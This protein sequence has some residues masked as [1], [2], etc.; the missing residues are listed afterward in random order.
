MNIYHEKIWYESHVKL[1]ND[2]KTIDYT[3]EE[4]DKRLIEVKEEFGKEME[5]VTTKISLDMEKM[6]R[7]FVNFTEARRLHAQRLQND[8]QHVTPSSEKTTQPF[9]YNK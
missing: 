5:R 1:E 9:H 2:N 3:A 4:I 7:P 8:T 6:V